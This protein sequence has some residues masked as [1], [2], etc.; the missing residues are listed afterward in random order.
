MTHRRCPVPPARRDGSGQLRSLF[1][2][3]YLPHLRQAVLD[4]P[5]LRPRA[6]LLQRV[7]STPGLRPKAAPGQPA[8][9]AKSRGTTRSSR[10]TTG[11][12]SA[13]SGRPKKRDGSI[14]PSYRSLPQNAPGDRL[15]P[16]QPA[17]DPLDR[18]L[19][20]ASLHRLRP[21]RAIRR[22]VSLKRRSR[23]R[24]GETQTRIGHWFYAQH[25]KIGTIARARGVH[26]D[27][28]LCRTARPAASQQPAEE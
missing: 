16:V 4:L 20:L 7:L 15:S 3:A 13:P 14:F 21:T 2:S 6:P 25:G 18:V 17:G 26:P 8:S 23:M 10:P 28:V 24:N 22:S 12:S 9:S 19:R 11:L 1:T 27:A 5:P